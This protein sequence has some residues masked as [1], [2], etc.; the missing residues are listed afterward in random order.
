VVTIILPISR[1]DYLKPVFDCLTQLERPSDTELLILVDGDKDLHRAIDK[2]L[3][4]ITYQRIQVIDFGT[5]P[6]ETIDDRRYR[7]AAVHNKAKN[8]VNKASKQVFLIE[9]DTVYPAHTLTQ[10]AETMHSIDDCAFIEAVQLGRHKTPYVGAW[11]VDSIDT[12]TLVHSTLLDDTMI[13]QIDAGGFYCALVDADL[14]T[15]HH[16]EPYDKVGTNGLS[17]DFNFGLY[18]RKRGYSCYIDWTLHTD[19]IGERGAVNIGNTE[20]AQVV[21]E[22]T[23][24]K[25]RGTR[26]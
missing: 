9:D 10:L 12:P 2:R 4:S 23:N 25:W 13:A 6:A 11:H 17:S 18:L 24:G 15:Q 1:K 8:F 16:F 19:H 3:D 22:L 26:A 7:I 20:P 14:Y 21:F 5:Q